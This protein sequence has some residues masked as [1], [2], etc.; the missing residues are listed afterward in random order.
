MKDIVY[1]WQTFTGRKRK[2]LG[3]IK[4]LSSYPGYKHKTKVASKK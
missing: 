3:F 4:V 1:I 2:T